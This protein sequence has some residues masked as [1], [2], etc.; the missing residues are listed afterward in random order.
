MDYTSCNGCRH[1]DDCHAGI[2]KNCRLSSSSITHLCDECDK[3]NHKDKYCDI[4]P[5]EN[6]VHEELNVN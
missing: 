6:C 4:G 3:Y 5:N 2:I 1:K